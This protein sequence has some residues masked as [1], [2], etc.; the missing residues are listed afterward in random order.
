M[1]ILGG[2]EAV[3]GHPF[4]QGH[5]PRAEA[6]ADV[7]VIVAEDHVE[8]PVQRVLDAPVT[9]H[10]GTEGGGVDGARAEV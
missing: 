3:D 1:T 5:I 8:H 7:G 4:D 6:A 9:A 10:H 2:F